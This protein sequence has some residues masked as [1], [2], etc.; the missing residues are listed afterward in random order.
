MLHLAVFVGIDRTITETVGSE[1][2][3]VVNGTAPYSACNK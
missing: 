1:T 3:V 2:A